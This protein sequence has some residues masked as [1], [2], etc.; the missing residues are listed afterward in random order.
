[1]A[2]DI[3]LATFLIAFLISP[4][5][6]CSERP[7]LCNCLF[8]DLCLPLEPDLDF[9]DKLFRLIDSAVE[10]LLILSISLKSLK[11]LTLWACAAVLFSL[12]GGKG[13]FGFDLDPI[14]LLIFQYLYWM[15]YV[16]CLILNHFLNRSHIFDKVK[17]EILLSINAINILPLIA[18]LVILLD[19]CLSNIFWIFS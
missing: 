18:F 12:T 17:V 2:A 13:A 14:Q 10:F 7:L 5:G 1:M 4:L 16:S 9:L 11:V 15:R 3:F 19:T 6:E 8:S